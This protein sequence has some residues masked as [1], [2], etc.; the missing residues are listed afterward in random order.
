VAQISFVGSFGAGLSQRG[1]C[2]VRRESTTFPNNP[3]RQTQHGSSA[4]PVG[5]ERRTMREHTWLRVFGAQND[6]QLR[7]KLPLDLKCD[8]DLDL[9]LDLDL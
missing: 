4:I 8:V 9:D 2:I 7:P 6:G 1:G 3:V 5:N